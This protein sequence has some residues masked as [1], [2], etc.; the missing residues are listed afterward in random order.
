LRED[1]RFYADLGRRVRVQRDKLH[2]TQQQVGDALTPRATRAS[3]AN[4]EA[5]KQRVLAHTLVQ[6]ASVLEVSVS[7]LLPERVDKSG[8]VR[9]ELMEK[10]S[11]PK[12]RLP[13]VIERLTPGRRRSE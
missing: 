7:D 3:I 5:G 9:Q 12:S 10:L 13:K 8:V 1:E 2:L 6:L 4:I 11:L